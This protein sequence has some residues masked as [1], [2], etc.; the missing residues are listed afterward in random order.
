MESVDKPEHSVPPSHKQR[1][2]RDVLSGN[3]EMISKTIDQVASDYSVTPRE[4]RRWVGE[5]I[6]GG[7]IQLSTE[8]RTGLDALLGVTSTASLMH[9]ASCIVNCM[10][11]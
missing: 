6:G 4:V 7:S 10:Q 11:T 9:S 5:D 2:W 3:T 1:F 8:M